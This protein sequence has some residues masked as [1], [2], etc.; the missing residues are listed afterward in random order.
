MDWKMVSAIVAILGYGGALIYTI[1]VLNTKIGV[2]MSILEK[3]EANQTEFVT[4][5]IYEK[6][7]DR[8]EK[9]EAVCYN[10]K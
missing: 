5:R 3:L 2:I 4:F 1:A 10:K 8:V 6:L 7:E 9:L